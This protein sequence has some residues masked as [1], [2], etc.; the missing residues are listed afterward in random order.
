MPLITSG[1]NATIA[2]S[3]NQILTVIAHGG[4]YTF[5]NP[6]GTRIVD[7]GSSNV[8][9]PF[10]AAA[11]VKLSSVQGDVYYE[12]ATAQATGGSAV[13]FLTD[14]NNAP[15]AAQGT[16]GV[17]RVIGPY[18]AK[19]FVGTRILAG[20]SQNGFG[21]SATNYTWS[22]QCALPTDFM[23]VRLV[24]QNGL[25]SAITGVTA[26][27]S[28]GGTS[29]DRVN[30]AGAWVN[31]T[32][33]GASSV[34]LPAATV[35]TD[36]TITTSDWV[37]LA[38]IAR[39]D[40]GTLPLLYVRCL[41]PAAN[42]QAPLN[43]LGVAIT[44]WATKADGLIWA[45]RFQSGDFVTTPSGM[46]GSSDP[47]ASPIVGVQYL[48]RDGAILSVA[49]FGDSIISAYSSTIPGDGFVS[50]AV[51]SY[52]KGASV[53]NMGWTGQTTDKF[54]IRAQ[55]YI[56]AFRPSHAMY[57]VYS[58]NDGAAPTAAIIAAQHARALQFVDLCRQYGTYP[59]LCTGLPRTTDSTDT[60]S[61]YSNAQDDLRKAFNNKV[62]TLGVEVCDLATA[63]SNS[64]ALGTASLWVSAA[65]TLDGLHPSE[66]GNDLLAA[67]ALTTLNQFAA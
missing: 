35:T 6:V 17:K 46:T 40:G 16:N 24:L 54:L 27:A 63:I 8:F 28:V 13:Q 66:S 11:T 59:I 15:V 29:T 43:G 67:K 51:S 61:S 3:A 34:T 52:G 56:P 2:V 53:A 18:A 57:F 21:L 26:C 48:A 1:A 5:E 33:S 44:G 20:A 42:T 45:W 9:G 36:P 65:A 47:S 4:E 58:P 60:V 12:L 25:T 38:S 7:S 37:P 23:A 41:T 62:A 22:L 64:T 49:A 50:R 30:N 10:P 55:R 32:F 14:A 19:N 31:A 39:V